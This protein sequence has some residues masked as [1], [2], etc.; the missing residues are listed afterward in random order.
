M[1][2]KCI[3]FL[4][5]WFLRRKALEAWFGYKIHPSARI[6][7]AWIFPRKLIMAPGAQ[8]DHLTVA[9]NLDLIE[10]GQKSKIGRGNWITGFPTKSGS[11]HFKHNTGRKAELRLGACA[12]I[13]KN[14]HID[15]TDTISI[16]Q[17]STIAGYNS[18]FLT[19]SIN[20]FENRQDCAPIFIGEYAFVGTNVVVLGGAFLP[21]FSVL[22][23]KSLL[24]KP[25]QDEWTLYGGVP[26]K[27]I[28]EI[29][30]HAK[31]FTR[32]EGFVH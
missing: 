12:A 24:N 20:V 6:G 3:T 21:S 28:S 31:Y 9:I 15:C 14:H 11:L 13:T 25:Q 18:Q 8:I 16:G 22:G 17:Y 5:P 27:A 30:Q 10:M 19:H 32:A 29:P 4:L 2:L 26:A 1:F 23:A 7:F